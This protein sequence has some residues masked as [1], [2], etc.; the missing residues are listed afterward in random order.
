MTIRVSQIKCPSC[1]WPLEL[2]MTECPAGHP[3]YITT[4]RSISDLPLPLLNRYASTY[5]QNQAAAPFDQGTNKSLAFCYLKLKLYDQALD[6]F[7]KAI[8]DNFD[9]SEVYFYA[10][11]AALKGRKAFVAPRPL[12]DR[13]LEYLNAALMIESRGIYSYLQAYIKYDYFTRKHL[14][15]VPDYRQCLDQARGRA[16]L[17]DIQALFSLLNVEKP[18]A[19]NF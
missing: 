5:R 10:A 18:E 2:G 4:F 1:G 13:A 16:T 17:A 12:I 8:A 7:A 11:I 6:A 19:L 14:R 9:D 3:V 15:T